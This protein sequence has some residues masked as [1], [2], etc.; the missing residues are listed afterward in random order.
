PRVRSPGTLAGP[1]RPEAA[2]RPGRA[3]PAR[4][5]VRAGSA[6]RAAPASQHGH[7]PLWAAAAGVLWGSYFVPA[8]W[9]GTSAQVSN[10]PLAVGMLAGGLALALSRRAPLRLPMTG[11]AANL[12]AGALFGVG[13][14]A[15]LGPLSPL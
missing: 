3:G 1:G 7:G 8:Q 9:A 12:A 10:F 15:L 14:L 13:N 5:P 2:G 6:T 11:A 4:A